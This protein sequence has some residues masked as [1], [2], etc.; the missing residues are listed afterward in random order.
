M[1]APTER[2]RRQQA[3]VLLVQAGACLSAFPVPT[4]EDKATALLLCARVMLL[5]ADSDPLEHARAIAERLVSAEL[6]SRGTS[7]TT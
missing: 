5:I 6:A 1:R 2:E 7:P 4:V 3:L